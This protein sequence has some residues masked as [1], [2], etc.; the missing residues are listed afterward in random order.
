MD[1][2]D[3]DSL[4]QQALLDTAR[5]RAADLEQ[6][7][8][9]LTQRAEAAER[10]AVALRRQSVFPDDPDLVRRALFVVAGLDLGPWLRRGGSEE[11]WTRVRE[12]FARDVPDGRSGHVL[13]P[14]EQTTEWVMG[15]FFE[16]DKERCR[17]CG[18]W[19]PWASQQPIVHADHCPVALAQEE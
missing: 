4:V 13:V 16:K 14:I 2:N 8:A 19:V 9:A 10:E 15:G 12:A 1:A 11:D 5:Q 3:L 7:T 18:A 17:L 6:Q